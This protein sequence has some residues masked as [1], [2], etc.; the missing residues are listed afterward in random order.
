MTVRRILGLAGV[1]AVCAILGL[2]AVAWAQGLRAYMVRTGSM[3]PALRPGDLVIDQPVTAGTP[4][5]VGE[6]IT[7]HPQPETTETHRVARL[8]PNGIVTKGDAN[9]T[10]DV[11]SIQQAVVVGR[12]VMT[13]PFG[14]LVAYYFQQPTGIASLILFLLA[15]RLAW[16]MVNPPAALRPTLTRPTAGRLPLAWP[17]EPLPGTI[18]PRS[19]PRTRR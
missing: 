17:S 15:L 1:L 2:G 6:V 7:F 19:R 5:Y 8:G 9:R 3:S 11:G 13:V 16:E 4:L 14:G 18:A 12:V 10:P